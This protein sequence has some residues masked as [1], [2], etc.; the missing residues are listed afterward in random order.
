MYSNVKSAVWGIDNWITLTKGIELG[1][2]K[3]QHQKG[4]LRRYIVVKKKVEDRPESTGKLLFDD[5]P[6]YRFS[7]Y[8][9]NID[10][11]IDQIWNIYNSRADCENRIKE[12]KQD[13]GLENFC[14]K[15]FWATEAS[16]R[17]IMIAYNLMSLFRYFALNEHNTATLNTL[18]SYCFALGAWTVNHSNKT[19]LKISLPVK[20]RPWMESI[21]NK[22]QR[23]EPPFS[24]SN[25]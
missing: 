23:T 24:Y 15:E 6:G 1:E 2:M 9:T 13:F 25:E 12:L 14:M 7:C 11:P 17:F 21:F 10:L 18:K 8:V 22:I 19:T 5:L 3:F 4:K 16:F 20:K